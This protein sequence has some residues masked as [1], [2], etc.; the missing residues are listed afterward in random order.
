MHQ[1]VHM[2]QDALLIVL[3]VL[4]PFARIATAH[5]K[6]QF[7][8]SPCFARWSRDFLKLRN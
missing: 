1:A 7:V 6:H 4:I 5:L 8:L 2:Q 3:W